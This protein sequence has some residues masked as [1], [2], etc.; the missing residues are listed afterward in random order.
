MTTTYGTIP[1]SPTPPKL[2]YIT[3]GKQRIKAGLGTRRPW[4]TMFDIRSLGIPAR[5]LPEAI[6]R[7][8]DNI[9]YFRMNYTMVML[10]ILFLSLLWHPYSLIVFV[11]LMAAWLFFYFLRDQPVII[12]GRLVDDR[13]VVVVMAFVTV[14]LLLLTHATVNIVAA[15]SVAVVVVVVHAVFRRTEDLF[16]EEEEQVIVS[17]AS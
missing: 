7:I 16:F 4:K 17:V 1:T 13:L 6:S 10:L 11:L 8:R 15:V 14:A 9:S 3:R 12:W 2:E 5:G